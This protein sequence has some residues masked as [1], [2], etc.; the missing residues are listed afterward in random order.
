M[1]ARLASCLSSAAWACATEQSAR[2]GRQ[3]PR[4]RRSKQSAGI[5]AYPCLRRCLPGVGEPHPDNHRVVEEEADS[6]E[7]EED[8]LAA[9]ADSPE[10]EADSLAAVADNLELGVGS[11]LVVEDNPAAEADS[12]ELEEDTQVAAEGNQ[13]AEEDNTPAV[14]EDNSL[15]VADKRVPVGRRRQQA[16]RIWDNKWP[17]GLVGW[18]S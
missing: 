10:L 16:Y 8:N 3:S 4:A 12:L 9:V 14:A 7:L 6:L 5:Q 17:L 18:H 15:A 2:A 11:T 1:T 13:V